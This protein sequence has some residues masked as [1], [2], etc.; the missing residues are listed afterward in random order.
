[1]MRIL[2]VLAFLL[3]FASV[4]GQLTKYFTGHEQVCGLIPFLYVSNE[5]NLPTLFAVFL[6]FF[7]A[8]LLAIITL[9]QMKQKAH[10]LSKWAILSFGFL[11]MAVDEGCSM[12]EKLMGPMRA[13]L[14]GR[15]LGV[16]YYAWV[17]PGFMVVILA[18]LFFLKF[19][20]RLPKKQS[21]L[22]RLPRSFLSGV[23]SV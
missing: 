4:A 23:L 3:I 2:G 11:F 20:L 7:A 6:L 16:F 1:M 5:Q 15:P 12:H 14:G 10:D 22:L 19:L 8:V 13:L 9:Y 18:G 21:S 17:I